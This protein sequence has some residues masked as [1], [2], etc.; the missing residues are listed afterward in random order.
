M[1]DFEFV[2]E[3]SDDFNFCWKNDLVIIIVSPWI[4]AGGN[5][6]SVYG[7]DRSFCEAVTTGLE[8]KGIIA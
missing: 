4:D 7:I 5:Y 1:A 8:K 3:C 6:L 2:A